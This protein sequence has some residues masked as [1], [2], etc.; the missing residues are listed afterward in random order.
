MKVGLVS[1]QEDIQQRIAAKE[2]GRK[3]TTSFNDR[4]QHTGVKN[5][6]TS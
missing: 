6:R 3:L 1:I 5:Q 4:Q 2:I